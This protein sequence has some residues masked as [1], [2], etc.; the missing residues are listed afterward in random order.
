MNISD[1][2]VHMGLNPNVFRQ[3]DGGLAHAAVDVHVVVVLR[4]APQVHFEFADAHLDVHPPQRQVT[5][6]QAGIRP[7]RSSH[8]GPAA[9]DR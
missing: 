3:I 4:R 5:Q 9:S 6:V 1:A 8:P 7:R 2:A